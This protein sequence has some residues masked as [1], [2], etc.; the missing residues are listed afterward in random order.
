LFS[1]DDDKDGIRI[2]YLRISIGASDLSDRV[3]TYDDMPLGETDEE[4]SHFTL[5]PEETDMIPLLQDILK[6]NP[7]I[8]ILATPWSA[9]SWMKTNN[10]SVGGYLLKK[11]YDVYAN[12]FVKYIQQ[13]YILYGIT[14]HEITPQNEPLNPYNNPSMVMTADEQSIFIQNYLGPAFRKAKLS[15]RIITYDHNCDEPSYALSVLADDEINHFVHGS[16]YHLYAGDITVLTQVHE[17]Y[18]NASVYFTE[19]WTSSQ[20]KNN[21]KYYKLTFCKLYYIF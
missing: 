7:N 2:S 11:Y 15:T 9:P 8:R 4:L 1:L 3:F 5:A 20:G 17:A 6:I 18:P 21:Y 10:N 16:A 12:Y 14:I 19:Q 13:M